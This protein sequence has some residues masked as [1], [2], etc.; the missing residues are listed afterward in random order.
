MPDLHRLVFA[1]IGFA[2]ACVTYGLAA[3]A[4]RVHGP[5][6]SR[7][8]EL[9][10][11]VR[12]GAPLPL[13]VWWAGF[14]EGELLAVLAGAGMAAGLVR[15]RADRRLAAVAVAC[16]AI[17]W[18]VASPERGLWPVAVATPLAALL[19]QDLSG[20]RTPRVTWLLVAIAAGGLVLV[21]PD[22]ERS[23]ALFGVMVAGLVAEGVRPAGRWSGASAGLAALVLLGVVAIDGRYR[24]SAL[25][26]GVG[27]L[28]VIWLEPWLSRV[29]HR[30]GHG[31]EIPGWALAAVHL[32][33][34]VAAA[35]IA[36]L[37]STAR[38]AVDSLARIG[39][40]ACA[41][42]VAVAGVRHVALQ[43][44]GA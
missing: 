42:L 3:L 12:L 24:G 16:G 23:L 37:D 25:V 44:K 28:G 29:V 22:T 7:Q 4:A 33:A 32:L 18:V 15:I 10:Q 36:G 40:G 6:G 20:R 26:G 43:L 30:L 9:R 35:R 34:V 41:V 17:V 11:L 19:L 2:G 5:P 13:V 1:A 21:L 14:P 38:G 8:P 39:L 31:V 27:C